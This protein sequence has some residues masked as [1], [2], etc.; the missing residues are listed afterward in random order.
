VAL[1]KD[2][3]HRRTS[4]LSDKMES[5]TSTLSK[6]IEESH[7]SGTL[8]TRLNNLQPQGNGRTRGEGVSSLIANIR[9]C[10]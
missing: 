5:E 10:E 7:E 9:A 3:F 1:M 8:L 2:E 6:K 4:E